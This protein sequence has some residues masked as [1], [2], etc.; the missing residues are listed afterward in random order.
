MAFRLQPLL[1][2]RASRYVRVGGSIDGSGLCVV[3]VVVVV[4]VPTFAGFAVV[5][6]AIFSSVYV[7][8]SAW[9]SLLSLSVSLS[10]CLS[11][12]LAACLSFLSSSGR[13]EKL[14]FGAFP[15]AFC[16]VLYKG[17]CLGLRLAELSTHGARTTTATTVKLSNR[18]PLTI[19]TK[20][21]SRQRSRRKRPGSPEE[22]RWTS[23]CWDCA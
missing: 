3:E 5:S 4:V 17:Y 11:L 6:C 21:S 18:T 10:V 7:W 19:G 12:S 16:M 22:P 8:L 1:K 2:S 23:E 20:R 15:F 13:R 9:L 14:R